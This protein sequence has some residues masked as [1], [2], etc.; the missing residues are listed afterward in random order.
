M[1]KQN[2]MLERLAYEDELTGGA[3]YACFKD[4]LEQINPAGGYVVS[5][6]IGDFRIVNNICGEKAV[7]QLIINI[8]D[9][10]L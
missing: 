1:H 7:D 4:K 8:C 10:L 3:N 2:Q 5:V 6:D 9:V